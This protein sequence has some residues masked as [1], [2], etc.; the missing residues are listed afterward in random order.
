MSKMMKAK[1]L[2]DKTAKDLDRQAQKLRD[3][4]AELARSSEADKKNV[5]TVRGLKRDL[6]RVLTVMNEKKE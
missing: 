3:K 6:A 5:R 4:L 1:E 2:R